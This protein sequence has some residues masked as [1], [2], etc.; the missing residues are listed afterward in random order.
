MTGSRADGQRGSRWARF[1]AG[2]LALG[3]FLLTSHFSP[4]TAQIGLTIYNDGRVLVRR[5]LPLEIPRGAST[6]RLPLGTLD[7]A[8]L[9]STDSTVVIG[10]ATYDGA[11]D[12]QSVLRRAVGQRLVF[13]YGGIKDTVSAVV[14]AVDPDRFVMPDGNVTY[15]MPGIPMF[16]QSLVIVDPVTTVSLRTPTARKALTVGYFTGGAQWQASYQVLLGAA[17]AQVMGAAVI[18]SQTLRADE[19]EIQLLAGAVSQAVST[20]G[21]RPMAE[22]LMRADEAVA[23]KQVSEQKVG[24]FHLYSLS[25]KTSLLPGLTTSVALFDPA[26]VKYERQYV[27]RGLI[28]YWGGLPQYGDET[29]APVEVSYLLLRP[30]KTDFGDRPLPGGVA[31]IFQADSGGRLQLVG[32][33]AMDHTPAGQDLRLSAGEAFDLTGKRVQTSY[34]TKRDSVTTGSWRTIA[35]ADY[36]V[37]ITNAGDQ[38]VTVDVLEERGGEWSV[39]SSSVPAQKVSSTITRFRV[40]VP[41]RGS[42]VLKYRVRVIW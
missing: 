9:F 5:T 7:P 22:G 24:E 16:P 30:R 26:T 27:I 13:R 14:L 37:T 39:L 12:Q 8:T 33:S 11:T 31:R 25:G 21:R 32:E 17:T 18:N 28:P 34:S 36:R 38:A 3:L 10:D 41:A 42:A 1:S 35:T 15:S 6:H 4:L 29:D 23:Y 19:A 20:V 2:K 40:P